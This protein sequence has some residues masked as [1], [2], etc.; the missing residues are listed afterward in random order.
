MHQTNSKH[1]KKLLL[2]AL[3]ILL[4]GCSSDDNNNSY[5]PVFPTP[6]SVAYFRG[7]VNGTPVDYTYTYT[8]TTTAYGYANSN[9]GSPGDF[10][11]SYGGA[12]STSTFSPAITIYWDNMYHGG[13]DDESINFYESFS[14]L[15]TNFLTDAQIDGNVRGVEIVYEKNG[16]TYYSGAGSQAGSVFAISNSSQGIEDGGSLKIKT[17]EGTFNCKLY[18]GDD[19]TDVVTITNGSYKVVLREDQ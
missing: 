5:T 15:P 19:P 8:S 4:F 2:F 1:M 17:V 7:N 3:P 6:D 9:S 12:I 10:W 13:Y 11:F 16:S 14:D 18:N